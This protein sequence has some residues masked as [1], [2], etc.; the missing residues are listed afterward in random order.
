MDENKIEKDNP[1][2]ELHCI[3]HSTAH[4]MAHAIQE[5]YPNAKFA[6][7]PVIKDG[8]YYD[9]DLPKTISEDDLEN[10]EK[11]MKEIIKSNNQF[12]HEEWSKDKAIKWFKE[13]NQDYKLEI[14]NGIESENVSIYKEGNFIDLCAGPHVKYTKQCKNFKLL[15]VSG[16][17]WRGDEKN[18]MLQRIYGTAWKTKEDLDKYLFQIEEAKKRDHRKLGKEMELFFMHPY[19]PGSIFWLPKGNTLFQ[20]LSN[21]IREYNYRNGYVEVRTPQLFKKDLWEISGHWEH[22]KENMFSFENQEEIYALK[23]MNCPSHMLIFKN[24]LRSYRDLPMRIHDQGVL[25]RNEASGALGGLTRVRMFSQD[26]AHLFVTEEQ[27]KD[28]I[29]GIIRMI[30]RIYSVFD[31]RFKVVLSTRPEKFMGDIELWNNAEKILE[32]VIKENQLEYSINPGD[33]AFYGPKIDYLVYDALGREHQTATTQLDFQL[34][35]RFELTYVD[36]NNE[37]K[38]PIVIHRAM[39][40]SLERFIGILIEHYA[41]IFP[42]WLA[43]IQGVIINISDKHKEFCKDLE[44][45]FNELNLRIYFNDKHE[46]MNYKIREAQLQKVPYMLVIGDKEIET[47]SISLR[48]IREGNLGTIKLD[49][50]INKILEENKMDF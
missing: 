34:P 26:D 30:K 45:K 27:L 32:E 29:N 10:I 44:K 17:Y 47:N 12:I 50:F 22:Y 24:Q 1:D 8:F 39:Y 33:G 25:H 7:G 36:K 5:L 43:P 42:I 3:R 18:P 35:R 40:G 21:K 41:G 46:T 19:S 49:D 14:I 37:Y 20:I 16:A 23:A 31:M 38:T 13:N 4:I 6:I 15:K 2:Y 11:K 28:E 9:I 48:H